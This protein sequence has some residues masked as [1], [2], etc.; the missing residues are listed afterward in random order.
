MSPHMMPIR[1]DRTAARAPGARAAT[2]VLLLLG[3]TSASAAEPAVSWDRRQP[4]PAREEQGLDK[5]ALRAAAP[6]ARPKSGGAPHALSCGDVSLVLDGFG[7]LGS[8]SAGGDAFFDA[9]EGPQATVFEAMAHLRNSGYLDADSLALPQSDANSALSGGTVVASYV[10]GPFR[11]DLRSSLVDCAQRHEGA[12]VQEW[13]ITNLSSRGQNLGFTLYV[14]GDLFLA[15]DHRDDFGV[16]TE[17]ALWQFDQ[18]ALDAPAAYLRLTSDAPQA[19]TR[20]RQIGEYADQRRRIN[21]NE[22]LRDG[23]WRATGARA[24]VDADGITDAGFDVSMAMAHD[25]GSIAPGAVVTLT[26]RLEWGVGTLDDA[27]PQPFAVSLGPDRDIECEGHDGTLVVMRAE[28]EPA[29]AAASW[30]W[31]VDGVPATAGADMAALLSPGVHEVAILATDDAGREAQDS[32]R[33]TVRDTT[34]PEASVGGELL[35]WPPDHR[36]VPLHLPVVLRDACSDDVALRPVAIASSEP[37]DVG[38]GGDGMFANDA[39]IIDGRAWVRRERQ[40]GGED[41]VYT[42]RC[43]ARDEAGNV[44]EVTVTA[45]VPHD[46]GRR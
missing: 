2:F 23:L 46:R 1:S 40:G 27:I 31:L 34:A 20:I 10:R 24:D 35:L 39:L 5:D 25:F 42:V 16:R 33:I 43:E 30:R 6:A 11:F 19:L 9:G 21:R 3:A 12:L 8:A 7:G 32:V 29:A 26:S 15:G 18:A 37:D 13:T 38:R 14:D 17:D 44:T 4:L 41:R 28:S 45:R 22:V 36:M